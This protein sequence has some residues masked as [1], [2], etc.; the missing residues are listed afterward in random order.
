MP[1]MD[2]WQKAILE[3]SAVYEGRSFI[4]ICL[5]LGPKEEEEEEEEVEGSDEG[6]AFSLSPYGVRSS[7][8]VL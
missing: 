4:I 1:Q 3:R 8:V 7:W 5:V 6:M 2:T